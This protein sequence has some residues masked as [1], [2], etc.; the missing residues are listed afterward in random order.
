LTPSQLKKL[1]Y[2]RKHKSK[3]LIQKIFLK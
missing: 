1:S 3:S 2:A